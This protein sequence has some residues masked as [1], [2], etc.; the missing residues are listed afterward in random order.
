VIVADR[1]RSFDF[2]NVLIRKVVGG[3]VRFVA[4]LGSV[5]DDPAGLHVAGQIHF[6]VRVTGSRLLASDQTVRLP[7][8]E[9]ATYIKRCREVS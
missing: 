1:V 5:P 9:L 6:D 8:R 3:G 7:H 2:N 4:A